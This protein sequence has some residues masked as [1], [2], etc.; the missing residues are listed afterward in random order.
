LHQDGWKIFI[1]ARR[2]EQAQQLAASFSVPGL[3]VLALETLFE[4]PVPATLLVNATP[5]GMTPDIDL[6]PWPEN[7]PLPQ[8]LIYDLVYHPRQTKLVKTARAQ[9]LPAT[10][11]IGMLIE[12]AAL[13]FEIWTGCAPPRDILFEVVNAQPHFK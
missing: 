6:S 12:Q 2:I 7:L 5:L 3:L 11:G 1:A 13:A 9:G 4:R 10:A 8:A